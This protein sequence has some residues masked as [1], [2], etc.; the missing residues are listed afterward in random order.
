MRAEGQGNRTDRVAGTAS[1]AARTN[2][3]VAE[4]YRMVNGRKVWNE[5]PPDEWIVLDLGGER[6]LF[7]SEGLG[8][9]IWGVF[10]RKGGVYGRVM[11]AGMHRVVSKELTM[12]DSKLGMMAEFWRWAKQRQAPMFQVVEGTV[13]EF[14]NAPR[15]KRTCRVCGCTE[16]RACGTVGKSCSWADR[17]T[18]SF[19]VEKINERARKEATTDTDKGTRTG[20]DPNPYK[21]ATVRGYWE[22][23]RKAYEAGKPRWHAGRSVLVVAW[24]KAAEA[25]WDWA[26]ADD[27]QTAGETE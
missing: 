15:V 7:V 25:G 10:Y 5:M 16:D 18:C 1:D 27:A 4:A 21:A 24:R 3:A 6:V 13:P 11:S 9:G 17:D 8:H 14:G 23:G 2:R 12:V 20:T 22:A 19:C 26:M